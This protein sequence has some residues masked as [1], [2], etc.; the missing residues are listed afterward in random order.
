MLIIESPI[1]SLN[2][3]P[4][5]RMLVQTRLRLQLAPSAPMHARQAPRM[6][7]N[8]YIMGYPKEVDRRHQTKLCARILE[9]SA[10]YTTGLPSNPCS[11]RKNCTFNVTGGATS[12]PQCATFM[13]KSQW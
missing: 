2:K 5:I 10:V 6:A 7:T 13:S 12:L 9:F 1:E 4:Q 8:S 11:I 3:Y